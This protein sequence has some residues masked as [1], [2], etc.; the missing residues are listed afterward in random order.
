MRCLCY[1][2][3]Y[4]DSPIFFFFC[5]CDQHLLLSRRTS[6]NYSAS[7]ILIA[8]LNFYQY[9]LGFFLFVIEL[10]DTDTDDA[11][12]SD[13][14][15]VESM[16]DESNDVSSLFDDSDSDVVSTDGMSDE[17]DEQDRDSPDY[18]KVDPDNHPIEFIW[19]FDR[20]F[21]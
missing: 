16:D 10:Q 3:F 2:F 1:C 7:P 14:N 5:F 6:G 4:S 18:H 19:K 9:F 17:D 8:Y 21:N 15:Y 20:R 13:P 11:D 12:D